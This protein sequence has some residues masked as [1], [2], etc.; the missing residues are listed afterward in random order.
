MLNWEPVCHRVV[1]KLDKIEE[2]DDS[3]RR[4]REVGLEIIDSARDREQQGLDKGVVTAIGYNSF[5]DF[6]DGRDWC[7]P[8]D[9]VLFVKYAGVSYED[10]DTKEIYRFMNDED[11]YAVEREVN[12]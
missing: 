11:I 2:A 3:Y 7:Q 8:G 4:A 1:V 6:G 12:K 10:P 9:R 5:K